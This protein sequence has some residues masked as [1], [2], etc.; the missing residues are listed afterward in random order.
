MERDVLARFEKIAERMPCSY[1]RLVHG[2]PTRRKDKPNR[3]I[4]DCEACKFRRMIARVKADSEPTDLDSE[5]EARI[6]QRLQRRP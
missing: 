3:D 4:C 6:T 2:K 5:M 1:E